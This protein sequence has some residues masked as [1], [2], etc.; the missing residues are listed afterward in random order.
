MHTHKVKVCPQRY[1]QSGAWTMT[2]LYLCLLLIQL[3]LLDAQ[4][5]SLETNTEKKLQRGSVCEVQEEDLH[6]QLFFETII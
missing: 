3:E 4:L 6:L 2:H 5:G 1:H